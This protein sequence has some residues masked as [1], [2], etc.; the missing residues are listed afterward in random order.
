MLED[1]GARFTSVCTSAVCPGSE[2]QQFPWYFIE[3]NDVENGKP[4]E[5]EGK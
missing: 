2:S 5:V 3:I 4:R 1:S